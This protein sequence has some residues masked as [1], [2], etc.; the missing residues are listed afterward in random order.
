LRENREPCPEPQ[1]LDGGAV[2]VHGRRNALADRGAPSK[3]PRLRSRALNVGAMRYT[4]ARLV[5]RVD[6]V[7]PNQYGGRGHDRADALR[8]DP[9][10][11][12]AIPAE[13]AQPTIATLVAGHVRQQTCGM[14][15]RL[16]PPCL[17]SRQSREF[18]SCWLSRFLCG[19]TAPWVANP[20]K[21][22]TTPQ[23]KAKPGRI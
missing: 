15:W 14:T 7:R 9:M 18:R 8:R 13:Q 6:R 23:W 19:K 12:A 1:A 4:P 22:G 16:R 5:Q 17:S 21:F 20:T 2:A 10:K 11:Q 3:V